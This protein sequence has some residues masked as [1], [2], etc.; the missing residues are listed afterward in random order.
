MVRVGR[1]SGLQ[2]REGKREYA[3]SH[4]SM[5]PRGPKE[6]ILTPA[7]SPHCCLAASASLP[8]VSEQKPKK[9]EKILVVPGHAK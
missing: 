9:R 2:P 5:H 8:V 1:F 4:V 3:C 7:L 6:L